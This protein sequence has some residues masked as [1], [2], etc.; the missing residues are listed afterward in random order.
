MRA[1]G[2]KGDNFAGNFRCSW[3]SGWVAIWIGR[4]GRA[5]S[6]LRCEYSTEPHQFEASHK[7]INGACGAPPIREGTNRLTVKWTI[8][9]TIET[10]RKAA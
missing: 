4:S 10:T 3:L 1:A 9:K 7:D 5:R 6:S 8:G 2:A